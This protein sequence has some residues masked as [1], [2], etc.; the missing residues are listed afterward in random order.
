MPLTS[1]SRTPTTLVR[2]ALTKTFTVVQDIYKDAPNNLYADVI[3]PAATWGEWVNG[4][5]VQSERQ[6]LRHRRV[7]PIR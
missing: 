7:P 5:Y 4:I 6:A 2:P 1:T 3:L